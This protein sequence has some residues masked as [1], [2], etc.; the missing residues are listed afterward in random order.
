MSLKLLEYR[1]IFWKVIKALKLS[2]KT[3]GP[4][5]DGPEIR[6]QCGLLKYM[7]GDI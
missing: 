4:C 3:Q 6:G 5:K 1:R 2:L 7:T